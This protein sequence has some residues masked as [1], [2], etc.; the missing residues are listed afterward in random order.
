MAKI[1]MN[2]KLSKLK[3]E[4][5]A[6]I[7]QSIKGR[8]DMGVI[9]KRRV[10]YKDTHVFYAGIKWDPNKR[11]LFL[12][13]ESSSNDINIGV[14]VSTYQTELIKGKMLINEQFESA[15]DISSIAYKFEINGYTKDSPDFIEELAPGLI[16][17]DAKNVRLNLVVV[18]DPKQVILKNSAGVYFVCDFNKNNWFTLKPGASD[19][20]LY[21]YENLEINDLVK[22]K[23][24]FPALDRKMYDEAINLLESG[25]FDIKKHAIKYV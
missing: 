3:K 7:M 19:L 22:D 1:I 17:I 18:T 9:D 21:D 6:G 23:L 13:E 8:G 11:M 24:P 16:G 15:K 25:R 5:P 20:E 12:T 2:A 10:T 4:Y 14:F